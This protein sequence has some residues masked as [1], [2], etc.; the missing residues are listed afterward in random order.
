MNHIQCF[1]QRVF[2]GNFYVRRNARDVP[3][4]ARFR[5]NRLTDADESVKALADLLA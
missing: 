4:F 2:S 3:T 1:I 5:I